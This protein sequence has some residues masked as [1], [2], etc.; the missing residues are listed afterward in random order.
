MVLDE[1]LIGLESEVERFE[2]EKG[3]IRKFADAIGDP[4][5][6]FQ[7]G[8]VAPPT[9][10]TTF[11]VKIPGLEAVDPAR[12]IHANEAYTYERPLRAGDLVD[13]RRKIV[14]LFF[15]DGRLG[16][17]TFVVA[18]LEGRDPAGALLFTGKT[19]VIIHGGGAA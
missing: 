6:V 14:D 15:K 7:R 3:A 16:R 4:N 18:T 1:T 11:R 17:M 12:F 13:C 8:E 19:T 2:V 9:F 5:P 10:P